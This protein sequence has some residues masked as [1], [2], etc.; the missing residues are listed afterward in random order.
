MLSLPKQTCR[1]QVRHVP[2]DVT[3][4]IRGWVR[5]ILYTIT[6]KYFLTEQI[7]VLLGNL[8]RHISA[9]ALGSD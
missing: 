9:K 8:L 5:V 4:C 1:K 3:A 2:S 7:T 6:I